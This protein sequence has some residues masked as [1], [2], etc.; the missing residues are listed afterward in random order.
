MNL[1]EH[2]VTGHDLGSGTRLS[3]CTRGTLLS[4][5]GKPAAA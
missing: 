1:D 3:P 4:F 5:A 2:V